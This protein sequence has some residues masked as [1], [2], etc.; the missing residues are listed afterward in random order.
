MVK[1]KRKEK[2]KEK[3]KDFTQLSGKYRIRPDFLSR[4][5]ECVFVSVCRVGK[6]L[7]GMGFKQTCPGGPVYIFSLAQSN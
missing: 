4:D 5:H 1:K 6:G 2:E 3:E 7:E